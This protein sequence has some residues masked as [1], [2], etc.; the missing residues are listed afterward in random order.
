VALQRRVEL[1]VMFDI[2][3]VPFDKHRNNRFNIYRLAQFAFQ[4]IE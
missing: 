4:F 2:D 1:L 3:R